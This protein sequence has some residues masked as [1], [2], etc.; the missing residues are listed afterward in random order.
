VSAIQDTIDQYPGLRHTLTTY[1]AQGL[2][3]DATDRKA[4]TVRLYGTDQQGLY[5]QAQQVQQS[6]STVHGITNAQV[7]AQAEEPSIQIEVNIAA[8]GK[9]GLKPGDIRRDSAVLV[10]GI[11]VGS[12]YQQQQIFD[13]TVWSQPAARQNLTD[14]QNLLLDVPAGGQVRLGDV[15]TVS[16]KPAPTEIDHD[17]VSRYIDVTADVKGGDLDTVLADVRTRAQSLT[18]P[19]GYHIEVSSDAQQQRGNDTRTLLWT[20]AA[21]IG[22]FMLLQ[23]AF[24]SWGRAALVFLTLP[25]AAAGG[26]ATAALDGRFLTVGA[27]VGFIAVLGVTVHNGITL[28]HRL[29]S[30]EEDEDQERGIDLVMRAVR[31]VA[32]PVVVTAVAIALLVAPFTLGLHLAGEEILRPLALVVLGGL[33]TST[34]FTLFVLPALYLHW[35]ERPRPTTTTTTAAPES[36]G[37]AS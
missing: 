22:I 9:Y 24:H 4:V 5:T 37:D 31:D 26:V 20:L 32:Y 19:L 35:V 10:A 30:L 2:A 15:A 27:L 17:Q 25:L 13:V 36:Q 7:Q 34:L 14:I 11:A 28:I 29:Q 33:V 8:A 21:A 18:L 23:A 12:Y 16:I 1:P 3:A 6:L